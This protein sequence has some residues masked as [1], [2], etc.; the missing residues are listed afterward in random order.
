MLNTANLSLEQA[1][2]ISVPF[3]F[4][5]TAPLFS[6][7]AAMMLMIYGSDVLL[8]RWGAPTLAL[9]HLVTL[10]VLAMVMCG[11]MLQMLPVLAGSPVPKVVAV[12][13]VV[14]SL[15]TLGTLSLAVS[16]TQVSPIWMKLAL[17]CLGVGLGVFLVACGIALFRIKLPNFTITGM[18]LALFSLGVTLFLGLLLGAGVAGLIEFDFL[19]GVVDVHLAWGLLGWVGLLLVGVSYQ[20]I[21]MFQVTPEYPIRMR[22]WLTGS[23]FVLLLIWTLLEGA[24]LIFEVQLSA[25]ATM[26]LIALGYAWFAAATLQ[27]QRKRRR[28]VSDITLMF[29]RLG[30]V[31]VLLALVVWLLGRFV[32]QWDLLARYQILVGYLM[33][34][35]AGVSVINGML[36]KIIPFLS[37]FHLQNR[38]MVM[39]RL[40]VTVPHM[41]AFVSDRSSRL[42][43]YLHASSLAFGLISLAHPDFSVWPAATLFLLSNLM[44]LS[45]MVRAVLLFRRTDRALAANKG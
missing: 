30:L 32:P 39:M 13:W 20:V 23:L 37:W 26:I 28:K 24:R 25:V 3:R 9:T 34:F 44:L 43:F 17:A 45:N 22:R 40:D 6:I 15:L 1:P 33:I 16:F 4:F 11:A 21:P 2:P 31:S 42:Q 19:I 38:Q 36:Y 10:G 12:G 14:H 8:T 35:C 18:R 27:L 7:A 29:W 41:K 5:L